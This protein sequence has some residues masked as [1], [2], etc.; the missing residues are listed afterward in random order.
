[1]FTEKIATAEQEGHFEWAD[2]LKTDEGTMTSEIW[3]VCHRYDTAKL[4]KHAE[5]LGFSL[6]DV[7]KA[8]GEYTRWDQDRRRLPGILHW[9]SFHTLQNMVGKARRQRITQRLETLKAVSPIINSICV[10]SGALLGAV[11]TYV[12]KQ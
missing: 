1:M 11:V 10:L 2:T 8:P 6:Y 9:H 3:G 7:P 4:L 12:V 5:R